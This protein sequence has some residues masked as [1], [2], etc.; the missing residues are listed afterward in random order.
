MAV[1]L[2]GAID[3]ENVEASV[4]DGVLTVKIPKSDRSRA[5]RIDVASG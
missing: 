4:N 3:P 1:A 5:G 2:P